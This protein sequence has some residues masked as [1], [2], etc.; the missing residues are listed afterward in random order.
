MGNNNIRYSITKR[1]SLIFRKFFKDIFGSRSHRLIVEDYRKL[2]FND[3]QK[4]NCHAIACPIPEQ[5]Y[6]FADNIVGRK[7]SYSMFNAIFEKFFGFL[8]ISIVRA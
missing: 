8:V 5:G 6:R 3:I 2:R 7:K 4:L 1:Q